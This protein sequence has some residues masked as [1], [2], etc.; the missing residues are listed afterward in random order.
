M[1]ITVTQSESAFS[2][3]NKLNAHINT[4]FKIT[5][6]GMRTL[7]AIITFFVIEETALYAHVS[8]RSS[9]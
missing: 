2:G 5:L 7:M 8:E 9:L 4:V 6:L 3:K 1:A